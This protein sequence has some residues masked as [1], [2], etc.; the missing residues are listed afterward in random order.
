MKV[1]T[2]LLASFIFPERKEWFMNYLDDKFKISED[3]VFGYENLDD[4]SKI[5][6][7][8][9]FKLKEGKRVNFNELFPNATMIHKKGEALYTINA[10]NKII[11]GMCGDNIGNVDNESVKIDWSEYQNQFLLTSNNEIKIYNIK[12]IF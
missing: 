4:Q 2:I 10:L 9:K 5:I 11:E 7:T 12:R 6:V 1:K 3:K 8:F